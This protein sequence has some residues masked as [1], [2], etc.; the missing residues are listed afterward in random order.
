MGKLAILLHSLDA[1]MKS[2]ALVPLGNEHCETLNPEMSVFF[3]HLYFTAMAHSM[4]ISAGTMFQKM[5]TTSWRE[6]CSCLKQMNNHAT[7]QNQDIP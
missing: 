1:G 4:L 2:L 6:K 7:R 5:S 3:I